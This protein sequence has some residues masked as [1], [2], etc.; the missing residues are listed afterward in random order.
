M[1]TPSAN[2]KSLKVNICAVGFKNFS[3]KKE[4]SVFLYFTSLSC[5]AGQ[6]LTSLGTWHNKKG[7]A[8][9]TSYRFKTYRT[10]ACKS[11]TLKK[12]CTRLNMR[13][14]HRSEYQDAVDRNNEN[15]RQNQDYYKRRQSICEHPFGTIKRQWGYIPT[16]S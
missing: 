1:V 5:P 15:I 8:G 2:T 16:H 9:E 4:L 10:G 13:I 3:F 12:D 7:D 6:T 14:I 11:C